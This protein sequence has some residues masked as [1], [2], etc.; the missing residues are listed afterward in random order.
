MITEKCLLVDNNDNYLSDGSKKLGSNHCHIDITLY[1]VHS[2]LSNNSS[3]PLLH[4]AFSVFM[5]DTQHRLLL[6]KRASTK[7]TF[8]D[9]WTNTC[10]SHPI[11]DQYPDEKVECHNVGIKRA[12]ARKL[13]HE[14]GINIPPTEVA[15]AFRFRLIFRRKICVNSDILE[16]SIIWPNPVKVGA[17]M[18]LI[19]YCSSMAIMT[20]ILTR[21]K[22]PK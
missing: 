22:S 6:Q 21:M 5:F 1:L 12:A 16:K 3:E 11:V 9:R 8:P 7:I 17:S 2:R 15:E 4:R 14:L 19:T 20:R 10:C 18:K 13:K